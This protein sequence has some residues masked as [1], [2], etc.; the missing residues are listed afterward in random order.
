MIFKNLFRRKSRS[1]LTLAG[2]AIGVAAM[3]ALGALGAGLASGYQAIA[4]GSQADLDHD[5]GRILRS[6]PQLMSTSTSA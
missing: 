5:P 2:I 1:L 3:I 4:G 6:L